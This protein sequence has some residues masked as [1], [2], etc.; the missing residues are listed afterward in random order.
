MR[1]VKDDSM[2]D[3]WRSILKRVLSA[4]VWTIPYLMAGFAAPFLF[5]HMATLKAAGRVAGS[6][7]VIAALWAFVVSRLHRH[8]SWASGY[9]LLVLLLNAV[10]WSWRFFNQVPMHEASLMG[11]SGG[12]WH[13]LLTSL[14]LLGMLLLLVQEFRTKTNGGIS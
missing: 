2:T 12:V 9:F 13:R 5:R 3:G 4:M 1:P 11:L 10:F 8:A 14:Y 7:F 6:L